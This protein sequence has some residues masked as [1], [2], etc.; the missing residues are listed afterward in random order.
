M[1]KLNIVKKGERIAIKKSD[2]A[3]PTNL[4]V[5]LSWTADKSKSVYDYDFDASA[6]ITKGTES[7]GIGHA[8]S[9][10]HL[11]FYYQQETL[12][13]KSLGDN[14]TGGNTLHGDKVADETLLVDLSKIPEEGERVQIFITLDKAKSRG[15]S[16]NDLPNCSCTVKDNTNGEV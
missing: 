12:A 4:R 3:I 9:T 1:S 5:E 15:Q 16:F 8:I 10:D 13:I 2:G 14:K 11:C 6:V 7:A